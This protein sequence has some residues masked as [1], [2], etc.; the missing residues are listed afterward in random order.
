MR[1]IYRNCSKSPVKM[2]HRGGTTTKT[3]SALQHIFTVGENISQSQMSS[4]GRGTTV[5]QPQDVAVF[6]RQV[7]II[8]LFEHAL[9]ACMKLSSSAKIQTRSS[10]QP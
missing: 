4:V 2:T 5:P 1:K 8:L 7:L 3:A 9:T 6:S 10:D